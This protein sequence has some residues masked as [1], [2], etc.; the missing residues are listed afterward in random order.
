LIFF[1]AASARLFFRLGRSADLFLGEAFRLQ[2]FFLLALFFFLLG[3]LQGLQARRA[4]RVGQIGR[5]LRVQFGELCRRQIGSRRDGRIIGLGFDHHFGHAPALAGGEGALALHLHRHRLRTAVAETLA[6][7]AGLDGLS[8]LEPTR[9]VEFQRLFLVV[10][11]GRRFA[12]Q[13]KL[14]SL[15]H[16]RAPINQSVQ[17]ACLRHEA[18]SQS[19]RQHHQMDRIVAPQRP[20][21]LRSRKE[22]DDGH[23]RQPGLGQANDL[24]PPVLGPVHGMNQQLRLA[25]GKPV[26][27]LLKTG[28]HLAGPIGKPKE[29]QKT[30]AQRALRPLRQ[31]LRQPHGRLCRLGEQVSRAG[32]L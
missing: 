24:P 15:R 23:G 11:A 7:L 8:E 16:A 26:L 2:L 25:S 4:F 17:P 30:P 21:E 29:L 27:D 14:D 10:F 22:T 13:V 31:I 6:D 19:T 3:G 12:H 20:P 1:L 5:P 32:F 9:P 28:S 18:F